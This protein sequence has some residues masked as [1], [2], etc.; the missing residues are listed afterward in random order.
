[1]KKYSLI[2]FLF[3][4]FSCNNV[5]HLADVEPR[6][7]K[8]E[9]TSDVQPDPTITAMIAPYKKQLDAEMNEVIGE[10]AIT[11]RKAAPQ[12]TLGNWMADLIHKK[13]EDYYGQ[14]IDKIST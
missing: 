1:M 9:S 13:S 3:L 5:L 2:L 6:S 10:S 8:I 7:S 11:M 4:S 12:S 14:D